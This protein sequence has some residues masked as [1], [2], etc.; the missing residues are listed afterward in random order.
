MPFP[1]DVEIILMRQ[2]AS[3]LALP[4]FVI[5]PVGSLVYFNESAERMLGLRFDETGAMPFQDWGTMFIPLDAAGKPLAPESLPLALA[6]RQIR[7]VH[8]DFVIRGLDGVTRH[9]AVTAFPIVSRAGQLLGAVALF[10]ALE[11]VAPTH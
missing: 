9:L 10:W 6:L 1:A 3:G 4:V 11:Q 2:W 5:D 8:G 7:P